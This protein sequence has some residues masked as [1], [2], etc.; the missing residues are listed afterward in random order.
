MEEKDH[1]RAMM[2]EEDMMKMR[3]RTVG[4]RDK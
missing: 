4:K 3:I 1:K 2:M